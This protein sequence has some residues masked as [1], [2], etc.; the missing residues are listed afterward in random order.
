MFLHVFVRPGGRGSAFPIYPRTIAHETV[1]P[2]TIP[3]RTVPFGP[4]PHRTTKAGGTHPNGMLSCLKHILLIFLV[5]LA[6]FTRKF[7]LSNVTI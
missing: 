7:A 3:T 1:P 6:V 4:Y 2:M 5:Q